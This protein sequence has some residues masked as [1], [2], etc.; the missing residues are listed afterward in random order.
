MMGFWLHIELIDKTGIDHLVVCPKMSELTRG[1][2]GWHGVLTKDLHSHISI[3]IT[4]TQ[5]TPHITVSILIYLLLRSLLS[6][7]MYS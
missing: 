5:Q 3:M 7:P 2:G 1:T 4:Q 6:S